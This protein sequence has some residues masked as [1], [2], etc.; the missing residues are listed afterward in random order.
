MGLA[1]ICF[2][3]LILAQDFPYGLGK[4]PAKGGKF[5]F[6]GRPT[7]SLRP[8]KPTFSMGCYGVTPPTGER[9]TAG[10][11]TSGLG[12]TDLQDRGGKEFF[13]VVFPGKQ[14][15]IDDSRPSTV[16]TKGSPPRSTPTHSR[17]VSQRSDSSRR[18]QRAR[19]AV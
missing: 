19:P 17:E 18:D 11:K 14:L 2:D 1:N 15:I 10:K 8:S 7:Q 4:K 12:V 6:A 3:E 9:G 16:T 13:S 5:P